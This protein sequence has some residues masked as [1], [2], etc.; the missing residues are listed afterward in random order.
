M[1]IL[2]VSSK[3]KCTHI[4]FSLESPKYH[5][6][7]NTVHDGIF[8][9]PSLK[10]GLDWTNQKYTGSCCCVQ[11]TCAGSFTQFLSTKSQKQATRRSLML[12]HLIVAE[13]P[14]TNLQQ[15]GSNLFLEFF[16]ADSWMCFT[17]RVHT[18]VH[19][20]PV[21]G[22]QYKDNMHTYILNGVTVV[23]CHTCKYMYAK[24]NNCVVHV[25]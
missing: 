23:S 4:T 22:G 2:T 13:A 9:W 20:L 21:A 3:F 7:E 17:G 25:C 12:F 11:Q 5:K 18:G 10:L 16:F 15:S 14:H 24:V 19:S 1:R 8:L 6:M